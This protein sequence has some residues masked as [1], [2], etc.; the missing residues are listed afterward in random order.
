MTPKLWHVW[1]DAKERF[2]RAKR[3]PRDAHLAEMLEKQLKI[4]VA[5]VQDRKRLLEF[6][7]AAFET[8]PGIW[9]SGEADLRK[10][11]KGL[12]Q[13]RPADYPNDL[14]IIAELEG[15]IIGLLLLVVY[16]R[17]DNVSPSAWIENLFVLK[18]FRGY[19]VATRLVEFTKELAEQRGCKALSLIVGLRN[20]AGLRFYSH[21]GF[22]INKKVGLA[23]QELKAP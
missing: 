5:A 3:P 20:P 12:D 15:K 7:R 1:D 10:V 11:R 22:N 8:E 6:Y 21:C 14:V 16:Y 9:P 2:V 17:F 23:A 13:W 4:R 19:K 18:A